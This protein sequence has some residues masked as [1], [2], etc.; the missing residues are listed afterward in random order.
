MIVT[1]LA[2]NG[3]STIDRF[4]LALLA[5]SAAVGRY[6]ASYLLAEQAVLLLPSVLMTAIT[7]RVTS[8]WEA[9]RRDEAGRL[10]TVIALLHLEL[11]MPVVVGL[12]IFSRTVTR[13]LFGPEFSEAV[14]APIIGVSALV[15]TLAS[16]A[17][18]GHRMIKTTRRQAGQSVIG[19]LANVAG[20]FA[21]VPFLGITGAALATLASYSL[22][23]GLAVRQNAWF[24]NVREL[25]VGA[26]RIALPGIT[27][28]GVSVV[29]DEQ[30]WL[31]MGAASYGV[32]VVHRLTRTMRVAF[33]RSL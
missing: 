33:G 8:L 23:A 2:M 30:A 27:F 10:T 5:D 24:I 3:L 26:F 11:S 21:L 4:L 16:Y 1:S 13:A 19:V 32:L 9:G 20:V 28:F 22:V 15:A 25:A 12:A 18:F 6:A 29:A 31:L 7:P 17:N 14:V